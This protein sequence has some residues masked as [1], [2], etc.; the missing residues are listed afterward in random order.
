M[1]SM[2]DEGGLSCLWVKPQSDIMLYLSQLDV[3]ESDWPARKA[4]LIDAGFTESDDPLPGTLL[5]PEDYDGNMR[6]VV[7]YNDGTMYF[8]STARSLTEVA[9]LQ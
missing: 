7:A 6:P 2:A 9:G 4:E 8:V 1:E 3:S 5:A